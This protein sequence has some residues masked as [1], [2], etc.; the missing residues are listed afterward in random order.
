MNIHAN[1]E[2]TVRSDD[3]I[4]QTERLMK[5]WCTY[6]SSML[7]FMGLLSGLPSEGATIVLLLEVVPVIRNK[8]VSVHLKPE[9]TQ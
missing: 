8:T 6:L 9:I 3:T 7:S 2:I 5:N 4:C 1:A